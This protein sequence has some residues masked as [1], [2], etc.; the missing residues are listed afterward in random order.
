MEQSS[1]Y[2]LNLGECNNPTLWTPSCHTLQ[3]SHI[4]ENSTAGLGCRGLGRLR[5]CQCLS[6]VALEQEPF[7]SL[8]C[9]PDWCLLLMGDLL[10][11]PSQLL[12]APPCQGLGRIW[13]RLSCV[14]LGWRPFPPPSY[15]LDRHLP[16]HER[17]TNPTLLTPSGRTLL[18]L[19]SCRIGD[20]LS[21]VALGWGPF[22]P[23]TLT[24]VE[25]SLY[26]A[27]SW[28]VWA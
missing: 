19:D 28:S 6:G 12:V 16:L 3:S 4:A 13:D 9:E 5:G 20:R 11:P 7:P 23:H 27:K 15:R 2:G 25:P 24:V 21:Y 14:I 26:T 10:A 18:R 17:S 1:P 22:F 8:S